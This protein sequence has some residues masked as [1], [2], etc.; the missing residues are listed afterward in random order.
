MATAAANVAI[1]EKRRRSTPVDLER[2][3]I[4][5]ALTAAE[6]SRRQFILNFA[7]S[8]DTRLL[9][10]GQKSN[11]VKAAEEWVADRFSRNTAASASSEYFKYMVDTRLWTT[12]VGVDLD[13]PFAFMRGKLEESL[14]SSSSREIE[15]DRPKSEA[16]LAEHGIQTRRVDL[17]PPVAITAPPRKDPTPPHPSRKQPKRR[18]SV[19]AA[20]VTDESSEKRRSLS[21]TS[22]EELKMPKL[23]RDKFPFLVRFG[24]WSR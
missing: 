21:W 4:I 9:I 6:H 8:R 12:H 7:A 20:E 18:R 14:S 23:G 11:A 15:P 1:R 19:K 16:L 17:S 22:V 13:F 5:K 24:R 10:P 2:M 3:E